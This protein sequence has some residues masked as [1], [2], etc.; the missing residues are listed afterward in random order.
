M[1]TWRIQRIYEETWRRESKKGKQQLGFDAL[2]ILSNLFFFCIPIKNQN[3][4]CELKIGKHPE[5][6]KFL[7]RR[8]KCSKT[9]NHDREALLLFDVTRENII[10]GGD[11]VPKLYQDLK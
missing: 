10:A 1:D 5:N 3:Q 8:N 6:K 2:L 9:N 7:G 4:H 11:T